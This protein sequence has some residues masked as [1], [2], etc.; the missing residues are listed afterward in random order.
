MYEAFEYWKQLDMW[1]DA[2]PLIEL[3]Q[4]YLS[5]ENNQ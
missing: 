4:K 5:D 3:V 2:V 1:S